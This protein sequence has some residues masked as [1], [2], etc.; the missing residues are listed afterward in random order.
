[1]FDSTSPRVQAFTVELFR[2]YSV[3]RRKP[4][5]LLVL[6]AIQEF[7][8]S[9]LRRPAE[10]LARPP[11]YKSMSNCLQ[12]HQEP[13]VSLSSLQIAVKARIIN[14]VGFFFF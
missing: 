12:S 6:K 4:D 8:S 14:K 3:P 7:S 10:I 2:N 9:T 13:V 11:T 5:L 1:M